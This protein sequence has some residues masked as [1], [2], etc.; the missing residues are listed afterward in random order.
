M[1][2]DGER[3]KALVSTAQ[4]DVLLCSPFIKVG[5]LRTLLSVIQDGVVVRIVTRWRPEEVAAGV[6]DL[7][8]FE[9]V[10]ER[11]NTRLALLNE[12]HAKL[13][14]ADEEG[15]AGSAN[16]TA[17]ALG[18]AERS[19]IELL[20]PVE[21]SD[22]EVA[23]LL[24]RL[25]WSEPATFTV[26]SAVEAEALTLNGMRLGEGEDLAANMATDRS[27]AWLPSCAAPRML[28][29]I[30]EDARTTAVVEDTRAEGLG[31]LRDLGVPAGLSR[32]DFEGAIREAL[33]LMPA[34]RRIVD[35]IPQGLTDEA[36]NGLVS[37]VRPDLT[38]ANAA[39]QWRIVRDWIA[40]FFGDR[41]EVAPESFVTR[42]KQR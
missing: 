39:I 41:F 24:W 19:N 25:E 9:A 27:L 4:R 29:G 1:I 8:V 40:V 32:P 7:G 28:W 6:S 42:L 12:L 31:D 38:G 20:L 18:W 16:L 23:R 10:N 5:V 22:V 11:P 14:L 17:A 37:A 3:L 30:Y 26:R 15:L 36:G 34:F 13:F 33:Q 21:R 2:A 35:R